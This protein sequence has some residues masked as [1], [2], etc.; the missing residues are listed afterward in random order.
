MIWLPSTLHSTSIDH[1]DDSTDMRGT[2]SSM[3]A[4]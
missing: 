2:C 3:L 4:A 1:G